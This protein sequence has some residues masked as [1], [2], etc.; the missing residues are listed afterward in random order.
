MGES[1][2]KIGFLHRSRRKWPRPSM[3][4]WSPLPNSPVKCWIEFRIIFYICSIEFWKWWKI[5]FSQGKLA[6]S[7]DPG[8]GVVSWINFDENDTF[9]LSNMYTIRFQ[10][11]PGKTRGGFYQPV[12]TGFSLLKKPNKTQ[13]KWEKSKIC[14]FLAK[15]LQFAGFQLILSSISSWK[16][17]KMTHI[18]G[19]MRYS[20][21]IY[22]T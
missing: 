9:V 22:D 4:H 11:W 16:W 2:K 14:N 19:F 20:R 3:V 8:T 18:K 6:E 21:Y 13:L 1:I 5:A 15:F 10:G 17:I 7:L 12:L